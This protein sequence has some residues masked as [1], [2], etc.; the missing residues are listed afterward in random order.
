MS[1]MTLYPAIAVAKPKLSFCYYF[2]EKIYKIIRKYKTLF[3]DGISITI[4]TIVI[5]TTAVTI[6]ISVTCV[7]FVGIFL[8]LMCL[9]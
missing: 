7:R 8:A 3:T 4:I 9:I 2:I 6:K 1:S 5:S